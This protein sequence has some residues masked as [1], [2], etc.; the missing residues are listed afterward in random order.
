MKKKLS[1]ITSSSQDCRRLTQSD[2]KIYT[3]HLIE[4]IGK[5]FDKKSQLASLT[6]K[7]IEAFLNH[8]AHSEKIV[9]LIDARCHLMLADECTSN[10][11]PQLNTEALLQADQ[12]FNTEQSALYYALLTMRCR[13]MI[14]SPSSP[15]TSQDDSFDKHQIYFLLFIKFLEKFQQINDYL[16]ANHISK[17]AMHKLHE[18]TIHQLNIYQEQHRNDPEFQVFFQQRL[19]HLMTI[20]DQLLIRRNRIAYFCERAGTMSNEDLLKTAALLIDQIGNGVDGVNERIRIYSI[21]CLVLTSEIYDIINSGNI[22][23]PNTEIN[24]EFYVTTYRTYLQYIFQEVTSYPY[25]AFEEN[26]FFNMINNSIALCET[27]NFL[28]E[29]EC[30]AIIHIL[31]TINCSFNPELEKERRRFL[32]VYRNYAIDLFSE[33]FSILP[34]SSA[35]F[36]VTTEDVVIKPSVEAR[37]AQSDLAILINSEKQQ[38]R[39]ERQQASSKTI[40]DTERQWEILQ[41]KLSSNNADL[42]TTLPNMTSAE[43]SEK[44]PNECILSDA[45]LQSLTPPDPVQSTGLAESAAVTNQL[46]SA[47]SMSIFSPVNTFTNYI[48]FYRALCLAVMCDS[49]EWA[50]QE[51][52][53]SFDE[54]ARE[55]AHQLSADEKQAI[56]ACVARIYHGV[57]PL[58]KYLKFFCEVITS[59]IKDC[60]DLKEFSSLADSLPEINIKDLTA[61]LQEKQQAFL[62]SK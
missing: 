11:D 22:V 6:K 53:D 56:T 55:Y 35:T 59:V 19:Q 50:N 3:K 13:A 44:T 46:I 1:N 48:N 15:L 60:I 5:L 34:S 10:S 8:S 37:H 21:T 12:L 57:T 20:N 14:L 18:L 42:E 43:F 29:L 4:E 52:T 17:A 27:F 7:N 47:T 51:T 24:I 38:K 58:P 36:P 31:Q 61:S 23:N 25:I 28:S 62:T 2:R 45:N 30:K 40:T 49:T 54:L 41:Q 26:L 32:T 16:D 9:Q 39:I 33:N